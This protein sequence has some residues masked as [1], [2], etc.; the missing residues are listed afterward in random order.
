VVSL[1]ERFVRRTVEILKEDCSLWC[2]VNEPNGYA[3]LGYLT[4]SMPP[5][6]GGIALDRVLANMARAHAAAY[7]LIHEIQPQARVGYALHYRPMLP[8]RNWFPPD[9]LMARLRHL[10]FNLAFPSAVS[11]GVMRTPLGRVSMPEVRGTQD[12]FGLNYYTTETAWFDLFAARELFTRGGYPKGADLSSTG[13]LANIPQ[14]YDTIH[15]GA[16]V[17]RNAHLDHRDSVEVSLTMPSGARYIAA[18]APGRGAVISIGR[19]R[20][21]STGRWSITSSGSAA[22]RSAS[23]C[24]AW[25]PRPRNAPGGLRP[26]STRPSASPTRSPPTWCAGIAPRS[27]TRSFRRLETVIAG[28]AFRA[29]SSPS[30]SSSRSRRRPRRH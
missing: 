1:F 3:G 16:P 30:T 2:T 12:Y 23:A 4:G 27:L 10:A 29:R 8:R 28:A 18:P 22:G 25:I 20:G 11:T 15:W 17:S 24:G 19:S 5:G 6:G 13:F 26:I 21:T 7:R 9:I 14:A